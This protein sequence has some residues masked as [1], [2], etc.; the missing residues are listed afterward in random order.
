MPFLA[1]RDSVKQLSDLI[2]ATHEVPTFD[3]QGVEFV[4]AAFADEFS[5][6]VE[7]T[8]HIDD[9]R[10]VVVNTPEHIKKMFDIVYSRRIKV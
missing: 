1:T 7:D 5:R 3:F 4:S 8:W 9:A 2:D 10:P 6:W